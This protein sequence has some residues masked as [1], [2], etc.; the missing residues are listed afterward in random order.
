MKNLAAH[1]S[2]NCEAKFT[3]LEWEHARNNFSEDVK[4]FD[5][6]DHMDQGGEISFQVN[7]TCL[8]G[9]SKSFLIAQD[10]K[11]SQSNACSFYSTGNDLE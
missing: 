10:D 7:E 11:D 8:H 4:D 5:D 3:M 9:N 6:E 2:L 1:I